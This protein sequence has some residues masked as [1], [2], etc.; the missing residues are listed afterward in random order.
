MYAKTVS[1]Y[2]D[3]SSNVPFHLCW[4]QCKQGLRGIAGTRQSFSFPSGTRILPPLPENDVQYAHAVW[5]ELVVGWN[6][7]ST[8]SVY[9]TIWYDYLGKMLRARHF[10]IQWMMMPWYGTDC[11]ITGTLC[12]IPFTKFSGLSLKGSVMQSLRDSFIVSL[13][14]SEPPNLLMFPAYKLL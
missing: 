10:V 9:T 4:C 14:W 5:F 6:S 13:K 8:L 2:W 7:Q 3:G 11:W 1:F 12:G